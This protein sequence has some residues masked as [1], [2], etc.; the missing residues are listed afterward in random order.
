[1]SK[2]RISLRVKLLLSVL[3]SLAAAV[4]LF[5]VLYWIGNVYI[6][7][8]VATESYA[9]KWRQDWFS[10]L[11]EFADEQ[12]I[13]L[14]DTSVLLEYMES[15]PLV[16]VVADVS[17]GDDVYVSSNGLTFD[18]EYGGTV[19][20]GGQSSI[21]SDVSTKDSGDE[22]TAAAAGAA[23]EID[24]AEIESA[25]TA[26][27]SIIEFVD[28]PARVTL[29]DFYD[30]KPYTYAMIGEIVVSA[31]FFMLLFHFFINKKVR[32]I[33][34]LESEVRVLENGGLDHTITVRGNDELGELA[35]GLDQMRR[36]LQENIKM[37]AQ[38]KQ[39]NYDLVVAVSHDLRT[40]LTALTLYLDL[41][42]GGKYSSE[43]ELADYLRKSREK[44]IQIK[45]MSDGLFEKF[46]LDRDAPRFELTEERIQTAFED[47]LSNAVAYLQMQGFEVE[48]EGMRPAGRVKVNLQY[49]SRMMDNVVSNLV[50]YAEPK[51]P[52]RLTMEV[53]NGS[54]ILSVANRVREE[55]LFRESSGV[56]LQNI[57]HMAESM[58]GSVRIRR[59]EGEFCI[60]MLW[61]VSQ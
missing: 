61:P 15:Q 52:V 31:L 49:L 17:R 51:A 57:R 7:R 28:G 54:L 19:S 25:E 24:D 1:M 35:Q 59:G 12:Q 26:S 40:P 6:D 46:L 33:S 42:Q 56:G 38:A 22:D 55:I 21:S 9:E 37:E 2:K 58:D 47:V 44:L 4:G 3:V 39:A 23:E 53:S 29:Y 5:F 30:G 14:T 8:Y 50:K 34:Q 11:Q 43:E 20:G 32:Y 60:E 36:S 41:V 48:S 13:T 18:M 27:S 45:D 16:Y 10:D